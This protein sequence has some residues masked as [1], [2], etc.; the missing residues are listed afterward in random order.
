VYIPLGGS[1]VSKAKVIR[2]TFIIF[3]VSGL[4]H[5]ANWTFIVWGAYHALLFMP[6]LLLGKNRKHT[7]VIVAENRLFPTL[8]EC[9]SML[10]TFLLV[11]IGWIIFRAENMHQAIDYISRMCSLSPFEVAGKM[12]LPLSMILVLVEW[13]GRRQ[14]YA[15]ERIPVRNSVLRRAIYIAIAGMIV[16]LG[17][18][19]SPFIYFQF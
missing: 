8:K 12:A 19:S 7:G 1:R 18:A 4:W 9:L 15:L 14:Q 6:L 2:N 10:F 3:L 13:F 17:G 11:V 5:G 16:L